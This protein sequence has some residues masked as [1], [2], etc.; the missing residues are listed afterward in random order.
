MVPREEREMNGN[1]DSVRLMFLETSLRLGCNAAA[2]Q[3]RQAQ[4]RRTGEQT[5]NGKMPEMPAVIGTRDGMPPAIF[6]LPS[7]SSTYSSTRP[8]A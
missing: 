1:A 3:S 5:L 2:R 6:A 4:T 7:I 8:K